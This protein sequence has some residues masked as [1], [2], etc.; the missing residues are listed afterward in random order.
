MRICSECGH[1]PDW[2]ACTCY[3]KTNVLPAGQ[4]SWL[5]DEGCPEKI[6]AVPEDTIPNDNISG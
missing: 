6:V 4:H 1:T 2:C 5:P 3:C